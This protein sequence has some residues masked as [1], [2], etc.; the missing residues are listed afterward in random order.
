M[1]DVKFVAFLETLVAE[2]P[3]FSDAVEEIKKW[4]VARLETKIR[5]LS[6]IAHDIGRPMQIAMEAEIN[7]KFESQEKEEKEVAWEA[8]KAQVRD[9][10]AAEKRGN[11]CVF[12]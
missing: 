8:L 3:V 6:K 11:G 7:R 10:L 1:E 9:A 2:Q 12:Q 4:M 5:K